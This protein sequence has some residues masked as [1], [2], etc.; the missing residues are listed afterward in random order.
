MSGAL[1]FQGSTTRRSLMRE[2][3]ALSVLEDR[4]T[5]ELFDKDHLWHS[6]S[7]QHD[8]DGVHRFHKEKADVDYVSLGKLKM[9]WHAAWLRS[10]AAA[11]GEVRR[12]MLEEERSDPRVAAVLAAMRKELRTQSQAARSGMQA[13][14]SAWKRDGSRSKDVKQARV[15]QAQRRRR[16]RRG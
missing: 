11:F 9:P 8:E 7:A 12:R 13:A 4:L 5:A 16:M 6:L 14:K 15:R 1:N 2:E 10:A 3:W